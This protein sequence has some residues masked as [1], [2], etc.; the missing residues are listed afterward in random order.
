MKLA[1]LI[2]GQPRNINVAYESLKQF[3][4]DKY[5]CDIFIHTWLDD[6]FYSQVY[7]DMLNLFKP[8]ALK[9]E[10]QIQ[11]ADPSIKD[12]MW[13]TPLQ[14][15][16]SMYYSMFQANSLLMHGFPKEY[17]FVMKIR[18]D[19]KIVRPIE[20]EKIEKDKLAIYNWTQLS[21]NPIGLSDVFAI[22]TPKIMDVY[23]NLYFKVMEYLNNDPTWNINEPKMRAEY[24]L[25]HHIITA[26]KIEVQKFWHG[27]QTDPS[28]YLIR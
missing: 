19:L 1:I 10:K 4:L 17:D 12:P 11:F 13:N 24:L 23:S 22:G 2:P 21:Y 14:N 20:L 15:L 6:K 16:L 28:F 9:A 8:V 5:E 3:Y 18:S 7:E 26:N 25:H 27:D